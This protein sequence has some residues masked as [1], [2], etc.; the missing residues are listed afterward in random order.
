MLSDL[1][2]LGLNQKLELEE[3]T[4]RLRKETIVMVSKFEYRHALIKAKELIMA[5]KKLFFN[6]PFKY[7]YSFLTDSLVLTKC[8]IREDKFTQAEEVLNQGWKIF[9][10]YIT[11]DNYKISKVVFEERDENDLEALQKYINT[12]AEVEDSV[13]S[14]QQ[15]EISKERERIKNNLII[16]KELKRRTSLLACF[17][18]LYFNI[19]QLKSAEEIYIVYIQMIEQ[20]YG[21]QSLEASNCYYLVGLFYLENSYLKKAMACMKRA[22]E[23]RVSHVGANHS[24]ISDCYYNIG[25]I[26]YVLGN[27]TKANQWMLQALSIR[28]MNTGEDNLYVARVVA[29]QQIYELLA[30]ICVDERDLKGALENGVSTI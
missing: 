16:I 23:I 29:A 6:E 3:K 8:F 22:L 2:P 11:N 15:N 18:T 1:E 5:S 27:K 4:S 9:N 25:V 21:V 13:G 19:G 20:N 14:A 30:Q 12:T 10:K 7:F 26:F 17:A 24:S 28:V